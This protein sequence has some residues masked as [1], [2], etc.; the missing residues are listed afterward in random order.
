MT[1][2]VHRGVD[3]FRAACD[4]ARRVGTLGLVPTMGAL[5]EGHLR[6]VRE[7][8]RRAETVAVTIFVNPTQFGPN[9]DFARYPRNLEQDIALC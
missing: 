6:L 4:A 1:L 3:D 9:E 7:A 8:R 2:E 5:H